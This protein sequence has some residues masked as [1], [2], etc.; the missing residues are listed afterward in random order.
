MET[1]SVI[2]PA[3][4]HVLYV[5]QSLES[6]FRQTR[7]PLEAIVMDDSSTDQVMVSVVGDRVT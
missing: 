1:I 6:I 7:Q 2:I 4:N 5:I 3:Y